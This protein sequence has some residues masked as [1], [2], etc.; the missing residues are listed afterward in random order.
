[1]NES[2][3]KK[4]VFLLIIL[5]LAVALPLGF[6]LNVWADEGS[7]LATTGGG[8]FAA[9]HNFYDEKQAPLYFWMLSVWREINH[10][11][12]F[13]RLFSIICSALAIK[14]FYDLTKRFF[15]LETAVIITAIFA[16]HPFLIW[17]S[18]E[19]RLYSLVV[20]Q[21]VLLLLF[22]ADGFLNDAENV[23]GEAK[24]AVRR[25][26]VYFIL[27]AVFALY[28][29]YYNG[30]LL[31]GFFAALLVAGRRQAARIY[32]WQMFIVGATLLPLAWIINR[33]FFG[34]AAVFQPP[35]SFFDG[36]RIL[37][38]HFLTFVL[39]TELLSGADDPSTI[40]ILRVWLARPAILAAIFVFVKSRKKPG[41]NILIFGAI[42]LIGN[43]CLFAVYF[44]ISDEIVALRH[45]SIIFVPTLLFAAAVAVETLPRRAAPFLLGVTAIFFAYSI[46]N[47][48]PHLAKR[49]DWARV[50]A[51]IEANEQPGDVIV[52]FRSFDVPAF[53][54]QY[55]GANKILPDEKIF[56]WDIEDDF[57]KPDAFRQQIE[58]VTGEIPPDAET[59][60]LATGESCQISESCA[61]LEKFVAAH[62]TIER[63]ADF[64]LER[65]RLLRRKK[66]NDNGN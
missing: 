4:I 38:N 10:S 26:R 25:A 17:A 27:T 33:Q 5:H 63:S 57:G 65:V 32:F 30:F 39:P 49:G 35:R 20:L 37:W 21:S 46:F 7:T 47:L 23:S 31:V 28:T 9:L 1:M 22:F 60:W 40:S 6:Y 41:D 62:Y 66:Q 64:Y 54:A 29:N 16:P 36:L 52:V 12:F 42:T 50:A 8:F 45:A 55:R 59:V 14:F 58:F 34:R 3:A 44:I 19:I 48:Y 15:R 51:Y 11:I 61:P 43:L 24:G 53:R 13:A 56:D 18:L 2:Q